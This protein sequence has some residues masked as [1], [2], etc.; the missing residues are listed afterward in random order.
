MVNSEGVW[1][2]LG[3]TPLLGCRL[4][5]GPSTGQSP[6]WWRG[7][8]LSNGLEREQAGGQGGSKCRQYFPGTLL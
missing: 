2:P 6:L 5:A 3:Q 7:G 1:E 4:D 8:S